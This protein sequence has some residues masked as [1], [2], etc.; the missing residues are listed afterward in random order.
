MEFPTNISKYL[1][2]NE[3]GFLICTGKNVYKQ[4]QS[5]FL[6]EGTKMIN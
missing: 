2:V 4:V 3:D 5:N 6:N 1:K